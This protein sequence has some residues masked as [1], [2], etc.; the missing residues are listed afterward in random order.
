MNILT[1]FS[2]FYHFSTLAEIYRV[3]LRSSSF[4][5]STNFSTSI[6]LI[7]FHCCL[8][9]LLINPR[10]RIV[11]R[12]CE[13]SR[14]L[15]EFGK[16]RRSLVGRSTTTPA[17]CGGTETGS[18]D[19][20]NASSFLSIFRFLSCW[21]VF[22]LVISFPIMSG[23]KRM[24]LFPKIRNS[25]DFSSFFSSLICSRLIS[26]S[27]LPVSFCLFFYSS[28]RP[29]FSKQQISATANGRC[30]ICGLDKLQSRRYGTSIH[31]SCHSRAFAII[32]RG[33]T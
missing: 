13:M 22:F 30:S 24:S 5:R 25:F 16:P 8:D 6:D 26:H 2:H 33:C 27:L 11:N 29:H 19:G 18:G 3:L 32:Q 14:F 21:H 31:S 12:L 28:S 20:G 23:N 9:L 4:H 7:C 1:W 17:I 15:D 10:N